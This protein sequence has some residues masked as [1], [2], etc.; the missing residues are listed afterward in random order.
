MLLEFLEDKIQDC[1]LGVNLDIAN[2]LGGKDPTQAAETVKNGNAKPPWKRGAHH[3]G[4]DSSGDGYK[5]SQR[6]KNGG[7]PAF[8]VDDMCLG[9]G[10]NHSN[11]FYCELYIAAMPSDR[12]SMVKKQQ[13]CA[14]CLGMKV[15]LTGKRDDWHPRHEKYCKTQFA[16]EEGRCAGKAMKS[17]FHITLCRDHV[18]QNKGREADFI[19][20]LDPAKMP[21][22]AL[23]SGVRIFLLWTPIYSQNAGSKVTRG[24]SVE[25]RGGHQFEVLPDVKDPAVFM[26][27]KFPVEGDPSQHLLAF[28]D[29]GRNGAGVSDR[30]CRLLATKVVRPGPTVLDVAGGKSLEIPYGDEQLTLRLDGGQQLAT[31]TALHM[32]NITSKFPVFRLQE[33]WEELQA[34][35]KVGTS[36]VSLPTRVECGN[37]F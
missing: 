16:C 11:L 10:G 28:Y 5:R 24:P 13:A 37:F 1:T 32:P 33:A 22:G 25:L 2:Y 12:F 20:G 21:P 7:Q 3:S 6:N 36:A 14:R 23:Q 9:C 34:A 18:N 19:G 26:M 29:S 8:Q 31:I 15:N 4:H 35:A 27:Q 30:G 17:Q